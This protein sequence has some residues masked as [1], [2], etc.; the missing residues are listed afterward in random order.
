MA[1]GD[2]NTS[3]RAEPPTMMLKSAAMRNVLARSFR[4]GCTNA[5]C[6]GKASL[7]ACFEWRKCRW[8]RKQ[9]MTLGVQLAAQDRDRICLWWC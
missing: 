3:T 8:E 1:E 6:S 2:F 5:S 4:L 9:M 7:R